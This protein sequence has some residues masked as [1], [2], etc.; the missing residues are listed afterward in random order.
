MKKRARELLKLKERTL[1][2]IN[3]AQER[4]HKKGILQGLDKNEVEVRA[5]ID[6]LQ[7]LIYSTPKKY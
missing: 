6:I 3:E 7:Y 5:Q 2:A 1:K 4:E